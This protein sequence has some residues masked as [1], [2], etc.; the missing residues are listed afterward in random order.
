LWSISLT[1]KQ[2][3]AGKNK[4]KTSYQDCLYDFYLLARSWQFSRKLDSL[5]GL[6]RTLSGRN[7][8]LETS[9][10]LH[11]PLSRFCTCAVLSF[12]RLLIAC[13]DAEAI[14]R[15]DKKRRARYC[16]TGECGASAKALF[17]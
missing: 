11:Q 14:V 3:S 8:R 2:L 12:V 16:S 10:K 6:S 13:G 4:P 5:L 15:T 9:L 17:F 1:K 7:P